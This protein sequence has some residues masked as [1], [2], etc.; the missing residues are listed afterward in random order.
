M[1]L[2][3]LGVSSAITMKKT[4]RYLFH[5]F[6][7]YVTRGIDKVIGTSPSSEYQHISNYANQPENIS[8][9]ARQAASSIANSFH[10]SINALSE[11]GIWKVPRYQ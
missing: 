8:Q 7:P 6:H 11:G 10:N 3:N 2:L 4:L 1:E 5:L 9:G